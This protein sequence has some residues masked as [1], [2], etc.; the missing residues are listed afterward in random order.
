M[1][2]TI[3][4]THIIAGYPN[5][6]ESRKIALAMAASGASY[7]EIQIPF[8]DPIADGKTILE[9]NVKALQNNITPDDCFNLM[10]NLKKQI[11]IPLL[12]MTYF[13]IPFNYGLEKFCEKAYKAGCYGLIIPDMPI[14]EENN[15]HY[16]ELCKKYDL[17][18][19]QVISSITPVRRLKKLAKVA[20]GFVYCVSRFGTTGEAARFNKNPAA[21]LNKVRKYIKIPIAL[22]FGISDKR[23]VEAAKKSADI[24][25]IGSKILNIHNRFKN[26]ESIPKIKKFLRGIIRKA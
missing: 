4:M 6:E 13:N 18:A 16:L 5:I 21:Y 8:S 24:I 22:G 25:V 23:Q 3:L 19:I 14:D 20:E 17:K 15:E 7:I 26:R 1:P 2:K 10:R 11:K 12:F 9:A